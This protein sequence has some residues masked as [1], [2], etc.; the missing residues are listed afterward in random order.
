MFWNEV[1][2]DIAIANNLLMDFFRYLGIESRKILIVE[3]NADFKNAN[4]DHRMFIQ[5]YKVDG[6]MRS[7]YYISWH[8]DFISMPSYKEF[9]KLFKEYFECS[10]VILSERR[11][12]GSIFIQYKDN[13]KYLIMIDDDMWDEENSFQI[14]KKCLSLL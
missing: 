13:N 3:D 10:V 12:D 7:A 5:S 2:C 1:L 8:E 6:D 11:D 14:I 9:A 4:N